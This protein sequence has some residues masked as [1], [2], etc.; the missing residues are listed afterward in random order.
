MNG[1]YHP[2]YE[3]K[4]KKGFPL[5]ACLIWLLA[6]TLVLTGVSFSKFASTGEDGDSAQVA[7]FAMEAEPSSGQSESLSINTLSGEDS[8]TYGFY[9]TNLNSEVSIS[10]TVQV[11]FS[12]ALPNGMTLTLTCGGK[13]YTPTVSNGTYTFAGLPIFPAG[14]EEKHEYTLTI[15][16][17]ATLA[18]A[19]TY[20]DVKVS[21]AAQQLD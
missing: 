14:D 15:T 6:M 10:Y 5:R 8:E 3:H 16:G 1:R 18:G 20:E 2:Q 12:S 17:A 7:A 19:Y 9:V 21:V 13:D 11:A 4:K